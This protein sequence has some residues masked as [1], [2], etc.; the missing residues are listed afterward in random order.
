MKLLAILL[1]CALTIP[2]LAQGGAVVRAAE[3]AG[4]ALLRKGGTEA[5]TELARLGGQKA[6]QEVMEQAMKE[7]GEAL[8]KQTAQLAERHGVL[9]VKALHGAPGTVVR[10]LDGIPAEMAENGLRAIAREPAAMQ[11]LMKEFGSTALETAAKHPGLAAPVSRLGSEGF[12]IARQVTTAEATILARH[13]DDI[14]K[15]PA[16]ERAAVM[17]LIKRSPGKV[18][19]W[20]EKHPKLLV[21]GAVA[22]T[23]VLARK[24]LF[25]E[26]DTAGFFERAGGAL[27]ETFKAPVNI[28]VA[29]LCGIIVLWA[30][31]KMRRVLRAAKR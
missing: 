18:L 15:L 16:A 27:Y 5:A 25:G 23:V 1:L 8:M 19:A 29:S 28:A 3:E 6:V 26:G 24:E 21:T 9:A 17:D 14:A 20:M 12:D 11:A 13:A 2:T 30:A 7:G 10:A 4:E 22:G 31:L